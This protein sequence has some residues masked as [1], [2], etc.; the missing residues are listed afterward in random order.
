MWQFEGRGYIGEI[1]DQELPDSAM[2]IADFWQ[3]PSLTG[4]GRLPRQI[5]GFVEI[6]FKLQNTQTVKRTAKTQ[7]RRID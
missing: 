5:G 2:R 6:A 3:R 4:D 1:A 7:L